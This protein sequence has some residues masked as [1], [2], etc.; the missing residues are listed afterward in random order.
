MSTT[1]TTSIATPTSAGTA[2]TSQETGLHSCRLG[3]AAILAD[4]VIVPPHFLPVE[5]MPEATGSTIPNIGVVLRIGTAPL[6]TDSEVQRAVIHLQNVRRVLGNNLAA[7]VA[8]FPVSGQAMAR[9][10]APVA[11]G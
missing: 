10:I 7:R 9:E 11:L 3:T 1:I 8:V 6:Q 5:R 2:I 4:E